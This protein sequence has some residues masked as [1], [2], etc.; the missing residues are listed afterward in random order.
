VFS[1]AAL[2]ALLAQTAGPDAKDDGPVAE[3]RKVAAANWKRAFEKD[4][5]PHLETANLLLYGTVPGKTLKEVG[6][7]LEKDLALAQK[8]L[9][10]EKRDMWA[11][12]LTV[13]LVQEK[14]AYGTFIRRVEKRHPEE[15][16]VGSAAVRRDQPHVVAGPPREPVDPH[17]EGQAAA[18]IAIAVLNKKAGETTPEWVRLGFGRATYL[19]TA[20]AGERAAERRRVL[21]LL[22][23]GRKAP[24]A[25]GALEDA[26]GV[27]LRGS[28]LEYLAYSGR[29]ARFVPFVM[30]YRPGE[31]RPEPTTA[32]ALKAASIT[33][34]GLNKVWRN[35]ARVAR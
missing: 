25:W 29:T 15:G 28:V 13:Y 16:E 14:A 19:Q 8:A 26:E 4:D 6:P 31:N 1:L 34:D 35:W 11:G 23:K 12:K 30:G 24:D 20:P 21:A 3:Q 32:D 27:V 18:Q 33:P 2:P 22:A 7:V 10:V 17:V 5:A 9:G